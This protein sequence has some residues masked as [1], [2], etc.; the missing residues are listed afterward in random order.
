[1][2]FGGAAGRLIELGERSA[3][4]SS[5]LRVPCCFATAMAVRKASSA[6]A[7]LAGSR[8]A[9]SRRGSDAVRL[10]TRDSR[11]VG[12][13][14]RFVEERKGAVEIARAGL[15]FGKRDLEEPV[16]IQEVLLPQ[17]LAPRRMSRAPR[18]RA[19]F[20]RRQAF[21]KD[22]ERSPQRQIMLAR[23]TGG[24]E[25]FCAAREMSPRINSNIAACNF[26]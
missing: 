9:A 24:S 10:R 19:A 18:Q 11:C 22:P 8:S 26:A 23:E 13:R 14:Q 1:M 7:G 17:D 15:G 16:E 25:P 20:S 5:K 6:G 3:A 21:E 12:G 4:R 2:G